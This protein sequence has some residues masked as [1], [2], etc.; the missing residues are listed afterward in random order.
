MQQV[1]KDTQCQTH[2]TMHKKTIMEAGGRSAP[3]TAR[4]KTDSTASASKKRKETIAA[5]EEKS[6]L[7][8]HL[9][10]GIVRMSGQRNAVVWQSSRQT[11]QGVIGRVFDQRDHLWL[12]QNVVR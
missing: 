1:K 11:N 2:A 7:L 4:T 5:D 3:E 9:S 6:D 12:T 8:P 10:L